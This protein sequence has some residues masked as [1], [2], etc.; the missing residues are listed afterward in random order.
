MEIT[1]KQ[2]AQLINGRIEGDENIAIHDFAK[3]EEGAK[4]AITFLYD[5]KYPSI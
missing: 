3:I 1:A 2:I 4:G 5:A